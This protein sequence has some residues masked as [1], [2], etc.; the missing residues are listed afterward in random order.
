MN[1]VLETI[2]GGA[3]LAGGVAIAAGTAP[4]QVNQMLYAKNTLTAAKEGAILAAYASGYAS[5]FALGARCVFNGVRK[6]ID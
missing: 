3:I 2:V 5:M 4:E 6:I 1:R